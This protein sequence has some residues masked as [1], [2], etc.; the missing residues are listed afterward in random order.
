MLCPIECV[1][2]WHLIDIKK[3]GKFAE[4]GIMDIYNIM[5]CYDDIYSPQNENHDEYG[6]KC[7]ELFTK[8]DSQIN[9]KNDVFISIKNH[10]EKLGQIKN[11]YNAYKD[12]IA[13]HACDEKFKYNIQHTV[14]ITGRSDE[15]F[16]IYNNFWLIA[17]SEHKVINFIFKPQLN[18]LNFNETYV[19]M[20]NR[21]WLIKNCN[22]GK[23]FEKFNN[24]A[25]IN[26]IMT[27]EREPKF[28]QINKLLKNNEIS[29]NNIITDSII[30]YFSG[31]INDVFRFYNYHIT[32]KPSDC[33]NG[34]RNIRNQFNK[35]DK[36]IKIPNYIKTFISKVDDKLNNKNKEQYK[37]MLTNEEQFCIEMKKEIL[38]YVRENMPLVNDDKEQI[39]F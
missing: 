26:C 33:T 20:I 37:I 31:S 28:Y 10:Y 21:N 14:K 30:Q 2:L 3:N 23:N 32:N 39:N 35:M 19:D 27:L 12:W 8:H 15:K 34:I 11:M 38:I 36:N 24:K 17:Y 13:V 16:S 7:N 9:E 18:N 25:I 6:C 4:T 1:L 22:E 29:F 5:Y